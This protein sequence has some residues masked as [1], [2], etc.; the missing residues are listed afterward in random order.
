[1]LP[2][3]R[4]LGHIPFT[5]AAGVRIPLGVFFFF[6]C[7]INELRDKAKLNMAFKVRADRVVISDLDSP[8]FFNTCDIIPKMTFLMTDDDKCFLAWGLST[9]KA[10]GFHDA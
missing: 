1:M 10:G 3:S 9:S 8:P 5:D 4:G 6:F 7:V 2:S